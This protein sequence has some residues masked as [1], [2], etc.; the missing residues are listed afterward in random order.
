LFLGV[1]QVK[2]GR[3][4]QDSTPRVLARVLTANYVFPIVGLPGL[5][6]GTSFLDDRY[7]KIR[8]NYFVLR[9]SEVKTMNLQYLL[10]G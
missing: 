10:K 8:E 5:E 7:Y 3:A 1:L 2:K 6:P 9:Y 4:R